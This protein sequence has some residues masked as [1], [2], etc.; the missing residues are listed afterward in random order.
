MWLLQDKAN[1]AIGHL[2]IK[3]G[4]ISPSAGR[5]FS[6]ASKHSNQ[7]D[8]TKR[9]YSMT[10]TQEGWIFIVVLLFISTGALL[11]NINLLMLLAGVM[12]SPLILSWRL[13]RKMMEQL[14]ARRSVPT[15]LF[16][17]SPAVVTWHLS[18]QRPKLPSWQLLIVD[19]WQFADPNDRRPQLAPIQV[20]FP[21]VKPRATQSLG[22]RI[23]FP[24]RG[25]YQVGPSKLS[26]RFPLGLVDYRL[27]MPEIEM[28]RVAPALGKLSA[29]WDKRLLSH[30]SGSHALQR[31]RGFQ[32]EEFFA[33]RPWRSG[34]S[35][36][37]IH[38]RSTARQNYPMV[39]QYDTRSDRDFVIVLDLSTKN[40]ADSLSAS[41]PLAMPAAAELASELILSFAATLASHLSA[42]VK[43]K[44]GFALCGAETIVLC[45]YASGAF[46]DELFRE[47][48]EAAPAQNPQAG[49]AIIR[50]S[51]SIPG[52]T[53]FYVVSP[54]HQRDL[55][56][57]LTASDQ[58][59]F[60]QV[61]SWI[62]WLSID[63]PEFQTLFSPPQ[64]LADAIRPPID[65]TLAEL[66][67]Q[68]VGGQL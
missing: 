11:R 31:K 35:A 22:Y 56:S 40:P 63:S 60:R 10:M 15:R 41:D 54:H 55:G 18:N 6:M 27:H 28:V 50:L 52:G 26:T 61:E 32:D 3:F 66:P 29:T 23:R 37:D 25:V 46:F 36:R 62:K 51:Q 65:N 24:R 45:D 1:R 33:L 13:T 49:L 14:Q 38:W 39:R 30:A 4:L 16:A 57:E 53:P 58:A 68:S 48:A 44:I 47:L 42:Q 19:Q 20:L 34:D 8:S 21:E 12:I 9:R 64:S 59:K 7:N 5:Q 67:M 43:G 2:R 17:E